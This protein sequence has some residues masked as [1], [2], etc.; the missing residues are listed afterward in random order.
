MQG[1]DFTI[2][3]DLYKQVPDSIKIYCGDDFIFHHV[4]EQRYKLA[5]ILSSPMIHFEGKSKK[6]MTT[7]G[8]EDI[9]EFKRLGFKHYLKVNLKYSRVKPQITAF[10]KANWFDSLLIKFK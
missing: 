2:R 9:E 10:K 7:S 1:W 8:V 3:R 5:Y 4:Y 6:F